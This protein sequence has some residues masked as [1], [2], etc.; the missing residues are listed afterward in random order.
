[1]PDI[2]LTLAF[3]APYNPR[4]AGSDLTSPH[5]KPYQGYYW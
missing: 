4:Q 2:L 1:M 5:L 3:L